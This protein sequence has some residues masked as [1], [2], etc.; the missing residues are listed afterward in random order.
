MLCA[1]ILHQL[2]SL[3]LGSPRCLGYLSRV[4]K[5][6]APFRHGLVQTGVER[7]TAGLDQLYRGRPGELGQNLSQGTGRQGE[8]WVT[9]ACWQVCF[10]FN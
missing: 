8:R 7:T 10:S 4:A 3:Q 9:V 2:R 5:D 1:G 6:G